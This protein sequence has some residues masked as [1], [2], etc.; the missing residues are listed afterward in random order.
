MLRVPVRKARTTDISENKKTLR[1]ENSSKGRLNPE[2]EEE[3]CSQRVVD[4]LRVRSF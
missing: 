4:F 1:Q 3:K 2:P